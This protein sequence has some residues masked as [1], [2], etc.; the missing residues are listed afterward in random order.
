MSRFEERYWWIPYVL[1]S[2]VLIGGVVFVF[3][4]YAQGGVRNHILSVIGV[5]F[6]LFT[7]SIAPPWKVLEI[8]E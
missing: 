7:I 8:T 6:I 1:F 2:L 5:C 3:H 4:T